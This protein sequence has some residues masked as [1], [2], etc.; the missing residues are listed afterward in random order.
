MKNRIE[1]LTAK[2]DALR[3]ELL[4]LDAVEEPTEEQVTRSQEALDEYDQTQE[5]LT[6]ETARVERM[7]AVRSAVNTPASRESG[8]NGG[9]S[10]TVRR[11]PF[12]NVADVLRSRPDDEDV[13]ARAVTALSEVRSYGTTDEQ[14]ETAVRTVQSVPGAARHALIYGSPAYR[15]A[16]QKVM[17]AEAKGRVA[18]LSDAEREALAVAEE[19]ERADYSLTGANGGYMLPTLLDPTLI[20][21]GTRSKNPVRRLARVER[22]SQNV[23]HGVTAGAVTSYWT[24]EAAAMTAG[25][26]TLTSP[27]VTASKMTAYLP[28]SYE[29]FEDSN[30]ASQLG[31]VI[32][33]SF[34][35]LESDALISGSGSGAPTGIITAISATAGSTV[36]A[37]TR[38]AFTSA[39]S[40][41]V[42]AVVNAVAPR[43]E[44]SS[45]WVGNKAHFNT[46]NT[47][48]PS[49]GGSLFWGNF[50]QSSYS[51]PPLLGYGVNTASSM[52]SGTTSGSV[53][54]ILG[55]WSRYLV[56]DRIGTQVE[57]VQNVVNSSGLPTGERAYIAHKRV[58]G[59]CLD[60]NAFRFLKA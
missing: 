25:N 18:N 38:G 10:V 1:E 12:E 3:A 24:A 2:R 14:R 32:G 35:D 60:V 21:T 59:A 33:E 27:A 28:G 45:Q 43:F 11:D 57:F 30:L 26:N 17:A 9:P 13:I 19:A 31:V 15:S 56:Y 41:D 23:W 49:G 34:D 58:G 29:I 8:F 7:E 51:K 5:A 53:L 50:N 48:S 16:F 47:M 54:L 6:A 40:A 42:Y 52:T 37:T 46:I 36:T 22:G 20:L 39:S 55:D 44:E 4:E